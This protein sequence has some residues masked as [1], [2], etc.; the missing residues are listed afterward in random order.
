[1][2]GT[3]PSEEPCDGVGRGIQLVF[4]QA[5]RKAHSV[6]S[7]VQGGFRL[8]LAPGRYRVRAVVTPAQPITPV[9][10]VVP[11][12]GFVRTTFLVGAQKH[13]VPPPPPPPLQG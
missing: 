1:M 2:T 4:W 9:T 3:C 13:V 8:L 11:A 6:R 5:G 10:V 12:R 7:N